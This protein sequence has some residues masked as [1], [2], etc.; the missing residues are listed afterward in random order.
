MIFVDG[1]CQS[2]ALKINDLIIW[3]NLLAKLLTELDMGDI[4][5]HL[6]NTRWTRRGKRLNPLAP[7]SQIDTPAKPR[8]GASAKKATRVT[9]SCKDTA[10]KKLWIALPRKLGAFAPPQVDDYE[11]S[12]RLCTTVHNLFMTNCTAIV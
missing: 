8:I 6:A 12:I 3:K 7:N 5:R 10:V 11:L 2:Q 4:G 1:H 9:S